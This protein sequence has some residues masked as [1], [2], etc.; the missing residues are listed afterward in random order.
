M[1]VLRPWWTMY[2]YLQLSLKPPQNTSTGNKME[3]ISGRVTEEGSLWTLCAQNRAVRTTK[4][5]IDC[6]HIWRIWM[7]ED[8]EQLQMSLNR[9]KPLHLLFV[10]ETW[11]RTDKTHKR[12]SERLKR[13]RRRRRRGWILWRTKILIQT[14]GVRQGRE[15]ERFWDCREKWKERTIKWVKRKG[16]L[17]DNYHPTL[18]LPSIA[19]LRLLAS[20]SSVQSHRSHQR[21]F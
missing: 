18:Q 12:Q 19:L 4:L 5:S 15:R 2:D 6:K 9:A 17:V 8:V 21:H 16:S 11:R 14:S 1:G 13:R 7:W 10:M 20:M 3:E